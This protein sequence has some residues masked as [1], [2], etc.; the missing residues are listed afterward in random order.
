[1]LFTCVWLWDETGSHGSPSLCSLSTHG[2]LGSCRLSLLQFALHR[3]LWEPAWARVRK[4]LTAR[5]AAEESQH[6]IK[7]RQPTPQLTQSRSSAAFPT[8]YSQQ[9]MQGAGLRAQRFSYRHV[10]SLPFLAAA[11]VVRRSDMP[12][13]PTLTCALLCHAELSRDVGLP[14]T[15]QPTGPFQWS[16]RCREAYWFP[17][18]PSIWEQTRDRDTL[19]R[20]RGAWDGSWEAA[21][22][23]LPFFQCSSTELPQLSLRPTGSVSRQLLE[24]STVIAGECSCPWLTS[25]TVPCHCFPNSQLL[26]LGHKSLGDG[27][28]TNCTFHSTWHCHYATKFAS[29]TILPWKEVPDP[30]QVLYNI[31]YYTIHTACVVQF[32]LLHTAFMGSPVSRFHSLLLVSF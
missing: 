28:R 19:Y 25:L 6:Y 26:D 16:E 22:L 30:T 9:L 4:E 17:K 21:T 20:P 11:R 2:L 15:A 12:A 3:G 10:P 8:L 29:C 31:G 7:Q 23:A 18:E 24:Q 5:Q 27:T 32:S 14:T 13:F 1:M